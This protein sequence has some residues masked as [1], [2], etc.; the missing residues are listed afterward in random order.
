MNDFTKQELEYLFRNF[1][2]QNGDD[3]EHKLEEK[4]QDMIHNY[5][6][7]D[8]GEDPNNGHGYMCVECGEKT[9]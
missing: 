4:L 7:H 8:W 3:F 6:E 2:L 9:Q 1:M 5:C